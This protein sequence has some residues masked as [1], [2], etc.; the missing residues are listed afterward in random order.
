MPR[1]PMVSADWRA[2]NVAT[3][4]D[5]T[6]PSARLNRLSTW[7]SVSAWVFSTLIAMGVCCRFVSRLVAVTTMSWMP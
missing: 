3:R 5:G 2:S 1:M 7:R 6:E 4:S